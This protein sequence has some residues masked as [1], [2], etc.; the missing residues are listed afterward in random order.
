MLP[1]AARTGR[2]VV[3]LWQVITFTVLI[4]ALLVYLSVSIRRLGCADARLKRTEEA[5]L[6]KIRSIE[7]AETR[8]A[9]AKPEVS[10]G[11]EGR[12]YL[13]IRDLRQLSSR[14][15]Q[16]SS[17]LSRFHRGATR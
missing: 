12:D 16:R 8:A 5:L 9:E 11:L 6:A 3:A 13:T 10:S 14:A 15:T 7:S 2:C 17:T 1:L 4:G